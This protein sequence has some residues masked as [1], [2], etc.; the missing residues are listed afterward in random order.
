MLLYGPT[1]QIVSTTPVAEERHA[2]AHRA[3]GSDQLQ[4]AQLGG[5]PGGTSTY[6]RADRSFATPPGGG[7]TNGYYPGGW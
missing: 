1:G 7:S 2:V 5:F 4:V 3:G 6:L